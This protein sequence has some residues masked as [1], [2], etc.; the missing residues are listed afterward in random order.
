MDGEEFGAEIVEIVKGYV[1]RNI[2]AVI[3]RVSAVEEL[4]SDLPAPKDGEPGKSVSLDD[5]KP[6]IADAVAAIPLP[7]DGKSVTLDEVKPLIAA[8]VKKLPIPKDGVG[9]AGALI[10]RE[11]NLVLTLTDGSHKDLGK[12]VGKDAE[13]AAETQLDMPDDVAMNVAKAIRLMAETPAAGP[14]GAALQERHAPVN[15]HLPSIV[16]PEVKFPETVVKVAAPVVNMAP[17]VVSVPEARKRHMRKT[18][19]EYDSTGRIKVVDEEEI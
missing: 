1:D 7:K 8:E 13:P 2:A 6:L 15:I 19:K 4:F 3:A 18:V 10:D 11:G 16:M 14:G 5:V 9:L 12:V 17:A